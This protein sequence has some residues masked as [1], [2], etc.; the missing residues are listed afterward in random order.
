MLRYPHGQIIANSNGSSRHKLK[1]LDC[2]HN[3]TVCN[4]Y[5]NVVA[6]GR[7]VTDLSKF[8]ARRQ[9][10][11]LLLP[12]RRERKPPA[13]GRHSFESLEYSHGDEN[14]HQRGKRRSVILSDDCLMGLFVALHVR[15][16]SPSRHRSG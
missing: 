13:T 12:V 8:P 11:S 14:E 16:K 6:H 5:V 15:E 9:H 10:K 4:K 1:Y 3:A 7:P 2:D